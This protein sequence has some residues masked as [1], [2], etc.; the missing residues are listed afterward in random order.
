MR[1]LDNKHLSGF[2]RI[3]RLVFREQHFVQLLS[4]PDAHA[5]DLAIGRNRLRH[6]EQFHA[7]NLGYENL[8]T[9]HLLNTTDH[10]THALVQG[11]PKSRHPRIRNRESSAGA[12]LHENRDHASP[13]THDVAV[14]N[15][16]ESRVLLAGVSVGLHEHF[17]GAEL[18]CPVKIDRVHSLVCAERKNSPG[19]AVDRG[20]N[21]ILSAHDV[22]LD[23][24]EWVVLAG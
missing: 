3:A 16:T 7:R 13:A 4:G 2:S 21:H 23:G 15:A 11:D 14:A 22:G 20:V 12:L 24:L 18:S 17:F 19:A 8:S 5:V 10:K 1:W 6:F 9:F